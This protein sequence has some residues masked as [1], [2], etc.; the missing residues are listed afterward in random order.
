MSF[1]EDF[2]NMNLT[3]DK[4]NLID[5]FIKAIYEIRAE[6]LNID[7]NELVKNNDQ[8]S[9]KLIKKLS[10]QEICTHSDNVK[11]TED[12]PKHAKKLIENYEETN[13]ITV[14]RGT[15]LPIS[16]GSFDN[17]YIHTHL[18]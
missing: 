4:N 14:F 3:T 1:V 16:E 12:V 6:E 13:S 5:V 9:L 11:I 2:C 8:V 15:R 18:I 17:G 10:V 7:I